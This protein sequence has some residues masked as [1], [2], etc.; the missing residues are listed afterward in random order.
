[1][2]LSDKLDS[3]KTVKIK[4][5]DVDIYA[6]EKSSNEDGTFTIK[7]KGKVVSAV[8][9]EQG[10]AV[11]R[12]ADKHHKSK[13]LRG[14]IRAISLEEGVEDP[15]IFYKIVMDKI[16]YYLPEIWQEYREK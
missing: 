4:D 12:G 7:Y 15:E 11:V 5:A 3:T 2:E 6:V 13:K 8:I 10:K 14:A 16:I 1:M 9:L